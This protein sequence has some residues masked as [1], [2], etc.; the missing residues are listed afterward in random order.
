MIVI[1]AFSDPELIRRAS[2]AGVFGYMIKPVS[3]QSLAA[4]I[5]VAVRRFSAS[6]RSSSRKRTR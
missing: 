6:S 3:A 2:E 5:E 4:Q 1:S